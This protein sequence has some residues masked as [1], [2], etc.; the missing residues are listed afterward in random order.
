MKNIL[1][2]LATLL[3]ALVAVNAHAQDAKAKAILDELSDK[4]RKYPTITSE[5]T[6]TLEDKA[7]DVNQE[8]KGSIKMK[9]KKYYI[10]LGDNHIYSDGDT[11][12]TYSEEMNEVYIDF[13]ETGDEVLNP[14]DVYTIWESGFK[15]YYKAEENLNGRPT[16]VIKLVP[17]DA[18]DKDYHTILV[19][20]DKAKMEVSKIEIKGKQGV[21]YTY[22]VQSFVT[23][24]DYSDDTFVFDPTEYPG[25]DEIDNR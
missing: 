25:V 19:Y 7:A 11:R 8:Q 17:V 2:V 12:W 3:I 6:F 4:T 1:K 18:E 16:H 24:A 21:N 22:A 23:T 9:G 15:Q 20:I 5:F 10:V 14:G 13:T